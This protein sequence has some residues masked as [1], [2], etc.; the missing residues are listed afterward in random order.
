MT[1][2]DSAAVKM[3]RVIIHMFQKVRKKWRKAAMVFS[4]RVKSRPLARIPGM[5]Q[6]PWGET[7]VQYTLSN[8]IHFFVSNISA[9]KDL[10]FEKGRE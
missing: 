3:C 10:C 7:T 8:S 2:A 6:P 5:T 9:G 1:P 4:S